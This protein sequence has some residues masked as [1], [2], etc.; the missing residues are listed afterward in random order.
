MTTT[1][2]HRRYLSIQ[3][4]TLVA[5]AIFTAACVCPVSA[6]IIT[7]GAAQNVTGDTDVS[8]NGTLAGA[9]EVGSGGAQTVNGVTFTGDP[10]GFAA[11]AAG[12]M[13]YTFAT[14][15]D[16]SVNANFEAAGGLSASY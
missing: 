3:F 13:T 15:F 14:P 10:G 6:A 7:W 11:I 16:N 2:L 1:Q 8:L 9:L 5:I 4:V 12:S